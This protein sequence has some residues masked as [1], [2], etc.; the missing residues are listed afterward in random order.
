MT[1]QPPDEVVG[2][3]KYG[4]FISHEKTLTNFDYDDQIQ[5]VTDPS[6]SGKD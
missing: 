3:P 2:H 6:Q 5:N 1:I 4:C